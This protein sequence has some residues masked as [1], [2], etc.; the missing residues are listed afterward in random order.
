ML[1]LDGAGHREV[2]D[3]DVMY[4]L[5]GIIGDSECGWL[6]YTSDRWHCPRC[7]EQYSVR[8]VQCPCTTPEALSAV[9]GRTA[10]VGDIG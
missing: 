3:E 8:V 7:N 10:I 6:G 4:G 2:L 1:A 9:E 5:P